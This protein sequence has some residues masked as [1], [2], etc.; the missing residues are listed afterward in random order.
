ML[1][2]SLVRPFHHFKATT[3]LLLYPTASSKTTSEV[4]GC[5][6]KPTAFRGAKNRWEVLRFNGASLSWQVHFGVHGMGIKDFRESET[7]TRRLLLSSC[8]HPGHFSFR[9]SLGPH[10]MCFCLRPCLKKQQDGTFVPSLPARQGDCVLL[11]YD[12]IR[13]AMSYDH[14][15]ILVYDVYESAT[16]YSS[17]YVHLKLKQQQQSSF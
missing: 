14:N 8:C 9:L 11:C 15:V 5:S 2:A 16:L 7:Q 17:R 12:T 4:R 1:Y 13:W 6:I 3:C 10:A